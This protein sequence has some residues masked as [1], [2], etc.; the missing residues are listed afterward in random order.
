[1]KRAVLLSSMGGPANLESVRPFLYRLFSDPAILRIPFPL[2]LLLAFWIAKKRAPHARKIYEKMGG[3]SPLLEQTRKQAEALEKKLSKKGA[4]RC[5]VGMSYAPPFIKEALQAIKE[6]D[7][8]EIILLPLYPQFSTTTT[9]SVFKEAEQTLSRMK[10]R[11]RI[12]KIEKFYDESGFLEAM[13]ENIKKTLEKTTEKKKARLLF[14]AHGLP[15]KI[16]RA[17]DPYQKQCEETAQLIVEKLGIAKLDWVLCYQSR[18]GPLKWIGPS[19]EEEIDRAG[20]EG[21]A[22]VVV[23]IAFVSE[24]SETLVELGFDGRARAEKAGAV[25]YDVVPT[26]QT[27]EAFIE[28]LA[29]LVE[30]INQNNHEKAKKEAQKSG[31]P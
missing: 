26:V 29:R 22:I 6:Y 18:V 4:Y 28:G 15:E 8:D 1:M 7:P 2:R 12:K 20:Q 30:K 19:T 9:A 3:A 27:N 17:G 5:F 25:F 23:P 14:S 31:L 13:S 16:I 11:A 10:L 24:H 21:K